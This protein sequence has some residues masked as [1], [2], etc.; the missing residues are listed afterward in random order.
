MARQTPTEQS[1]RGRSRRRCGPRSSAGGAG[2]FPPV[3]EDAEVVLRDGSTV[4][5]RPVV[6]ADEHGLADFFL[7]L[8][9][10]GRIFR[11]FSGA[12]NVERWAAQA[13][14]TGEDEVGLV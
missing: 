12:T 13:A 9:E 1:C 7:G 8:S 10:Q 5:V 6:P 2:R 4:R 14:N 11:F 3:P